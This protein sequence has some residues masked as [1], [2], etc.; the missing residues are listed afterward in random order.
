MS[1]KSVPKDTHVADGRRASSS[2]PSRQQCSPLVGDNTAQVEPH[3]LRVT[4][5]ESV[6]YDPVDNQRRVN[7]SNSILIQLISRAE[8]YYLLLKLNVK[9]IL[10]K[11]DLSSPM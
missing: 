9:W 6:I 11:Q 10:H 5:H 2:P 4:S 3:S 8:F 1:G 7:Y